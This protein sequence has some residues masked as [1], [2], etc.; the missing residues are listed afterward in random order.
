M[1]QGSKVCQEQW[2]KLTWSGQAR[3]AGHGHFKPPSK[4]HASHCGNSGLRPAL[5]QFAEVL[6][7]S[8]AYEDA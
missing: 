1:K 7:N 2:R 3:V 5:Q 4:G 8:A 6:I